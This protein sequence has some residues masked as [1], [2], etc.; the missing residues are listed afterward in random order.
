MAND[1]IMK[2]ELISFETAKTAKEKGFDW[3][4]LDFYSKNDI[5]NYLEEPYEYDFKVNAN[6]ENEDNFGYGL[7]WSAPT[8][9]LLQ[10][11]LRDEHDLWV[12]VTI[13]TYP[14][15]NNICTS[16]YLFKEGGVKE[17]IYPYQTDGLSHSL[18]YE[19]ALEKGLFE[20]L[21][22]IK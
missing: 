21:K 2:E 4:C 22:L 17:A 16:I 9:S 8:Q 6:K 1:K 14:R 12:E 5:C 19:E 7:T 20:A 18:T 13:N 3:E 10:K 15:P 11:W